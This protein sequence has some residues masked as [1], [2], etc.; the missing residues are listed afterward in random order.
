[1]DLLLTG[2]AGRTKRR[3]LHVADTVAQG[4]CLQS[5]NP[6]VSDRGCS[7]LQVLVLVLVQDPSV[8]AYLCHEGIANCRCRSR[9][10]GRKIEHRMG[11]KP[12]QFL[13]V[14]QNNVQYWLYA[15]MMQMMLDFRRRRMH[16]ASRYG[17]YRT[18]TTGL[19]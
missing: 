5:C 14:S 9:R 2:P 19:D 6:L 16:A 13:I 12:Y 7:R 8:V 17:H 3:R 11:D 1:M 4:G 15:H 10:R 18:T